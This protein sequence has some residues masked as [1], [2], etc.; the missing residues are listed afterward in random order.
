MSDQTGNASLSSPLPVPPSILISSLIPSVRP[1]HS[2]PTS[3]PL[4]ILPS[5]SPSIPS[6]PLSAF[7]LSTSLS[8]ALCNKPT[9]VLLPSRK[10]LKDVDRQ[11]LSLKA[12]EFAVHSLYKVKLNPKHHCSL[13][14]VLVALRI[15]KVTTLWF[16]LLY[17]SQIENG[18][19]GNSEGTSTGQRNSQ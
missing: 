9:P 1:S 8:G 18:L 4:L 13:I 6:L 10:F 11:R 12:M 5:F 2:L 17:W 7:Q 3:F 14:G 19:K 15:E 16:G